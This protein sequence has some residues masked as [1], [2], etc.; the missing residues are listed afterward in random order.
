[1]A[2]AETMSISHTT[3]S[4]DEGENER[5]LRLA[6][7]EKAKRERVKLAAAYR[8]IARMGLDDGIAGHISLRVPDAPDYFWVNPFGKL[9]AEVTAENLVLVNHHGE[10][11]EGG[12]MINFAG[13]CIHSAIHQTRADIHCAA[14]THPPGGTAFS[15]LGIEIEPLDQVGCSFFE[16]HVLHTEYGGVVLDS[17]YAQGIANALGTRRSLVLQNHGLLTCGGTVEQALID[18]LDM[19]RTCNVNLKAY[20]TGKKVHPVPA[21][22]ARQ[23][24]A[25]Y[26]QPMRYPFQFASLIRW[27]NK[28]E[29]DYDPW[30]G[31]EYVPMM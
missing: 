24:R 15:A 31:G 22:A 12:P 9:F 16:D 8:I 10:I 17:D 19:E 1:M 30:F 13:F 25:V 20:A 7:T 23:A 6:N 21:E 14:H 5:V 28:F 26:T 2:S 18:M 27:L 11:I 4:S 3:R 29:T